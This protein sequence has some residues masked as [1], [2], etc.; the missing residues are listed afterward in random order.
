MAHRFLSYLTFC[1]EVLNWG[2]SVSFIFNVCLEVLKGLSHEID[3]KNVV[4]N[5]QILA[6]RAA[7][8]FFNFSEAALIFN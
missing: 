5:G 8:G 4:E 6:L 1:L 3:F 7:A 2:F